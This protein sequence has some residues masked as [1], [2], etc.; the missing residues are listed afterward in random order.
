MSPFHLHIV[1]L[2]TIILF[3]FVLRCNINTYLFVKSRE[4]LTFRPT[5]LCNVCM[6]IRKCVHSIYYVSKCLYLCIIFIIVGLV[7]QMS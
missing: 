6:C 3:Y 5:D 1:R 7:A 2:M 4:M